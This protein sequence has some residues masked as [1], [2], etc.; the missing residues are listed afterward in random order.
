MCK[1]ITQA[2]KTVENAVIETF[3][4]NRKAY[5]TRRLKIALA[6]QKVILSRRKI[7]K[8]MAKYGLISRYTKANFKPQKT[9]ANNETCENLLNREFNQKDKN[10]IVSDSTYVRVGLV[11]NYVY[12]IVDLRKREVV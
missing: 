3:H 6:S 4:S 9:A 1:E 8:I 7:G 5:G 10:I 11:W 12:T 2:D